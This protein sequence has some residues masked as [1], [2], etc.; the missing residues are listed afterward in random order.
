M[1][2]TMRTQ[3]GSAIETCQS[4]AVESWTMTC[5]TRCKERGLANGF[6]TCIP[7]DRRHGVASEIFGVSMTLSVRCLMRVVH[8][9]SRDSVR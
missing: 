2:G 8:H 5:R 1:D 6:Y 4:E 7:M 3:C 9:G